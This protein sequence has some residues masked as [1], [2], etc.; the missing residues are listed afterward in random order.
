M[1]K[2]LKDFPWMEKDDFATVLFAAARCSTSPQWVAFQR[3]GE[4]DKN[5]LLIDKNSEYYGKKAPRL[6]VL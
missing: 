1:E 5:V 4:G 6:S 2:L 3:S